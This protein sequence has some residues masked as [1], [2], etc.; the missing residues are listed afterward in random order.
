LE[1]RLLG[2]DHHSD[3]QITRRLCFIR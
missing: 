3:V 2:V 1:I